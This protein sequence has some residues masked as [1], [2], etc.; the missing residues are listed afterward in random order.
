[1]KTY[2]GTSKWESGGFRT[3]YFCSVLVNGVPLKSAVINPK[4][5][6]KKVSRD[7]HWGY[8]GIYPLNLAVSILVDFFDPNEYGEDFKIPEDI[9]FSFY[10][11][12]IV[13]LKTDKWKITSDEIEKYLRRKL[14][15]EEEHLQ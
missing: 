6:T 4:R 2:I 5:D 7:F 3:H 9:L 1:M 11:E 10:E 15:E 13:N 8:R 14:S 12:L